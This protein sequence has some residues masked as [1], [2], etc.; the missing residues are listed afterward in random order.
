MAHLK[1]SPHGGDVYAASRESGRD[2]TQLIDF[3]ASINPLGPSPLVWRAITGARHVLSHY[4]DPECR[5]LR[6]A[7]ATQWR[8]E[9]GRIVA[10]NGSMELI[11]ALPHALKLDHLLLAQPTFS[12]YAA[13][14]A[15]AGGQVT[16]VCADRREEYALP[17]ER[18]C[19]LLERQRKESRRIDGVVLC[20]PNSPT[21]QACGAEDVMKLARVAQRLGVWVIV[22]E[23][24]ADYCPERSI[25]PLPS[26]WSRVVVLR[27]LTKFYGLPGLRVGYAVAAPAVVQKF[28]RELPPWSVNAMGQVAALAALQDTAHARKSLRFVMKERSR[29]ARLLAALPGC[30]VFPAHANFIFMELPR[31]WHAR[32]MTEQ[33]RGE[34]LLIRDC[35]AVPGANA[36]SIRIAVRPRGDNDRLITSLSRLLRKGP[37]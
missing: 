11:Y 33:L 36:R 25:L 18:L 1:T 28:R 4:P 7:A 2:M 8:C 9:P 26:S 15:R 31:E 30:T 35:S 29:F 19:R 5:D 10:G 17:V 22:D 14:M 24:F 32:M 27:S 37:A 20:N 34:G 13:S 23:T 21:G 16:T 3:S 6:Q 12:E